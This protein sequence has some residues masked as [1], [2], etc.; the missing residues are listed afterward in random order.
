MRRYRA[1]LNEGSLTNEQIKQL[2]SFKEDEKT[3]L[4]KLQRYY[5]GDNPGIMD[6]VVI[7]GQNQVPVPYG[8]LLVKIV[9]GFMY[10]AGLISYAVAD[11][12]N[13]EDAYF[14]ALE[15]IFQA[16]REAEL[17][18]ELGKDQTVFGEA[19]E[20]HYIDND[21]AVDQFAKVPVTEF[22]PVYN[23]DIKPKLVAGIRYFK[24]AETNIQQ[25]QV[26]VYYAEKIDYF[27]LIGGTLRA[28]ET[29]SHPYGQVPVVIYRNNEDLKGDIEH[30]QK[31]IDAYDVMVSTF[32]DDEEKFAEAILLI[33]GKYLDDET[34][35]KLKKLRVIDNLHEK[36][37]LEY[38]TKDLSTS[39]RKEL[40]DIIRQEIHR[41]SLI[42][43]M[44][45]TSVL[46][47][48]SGEAFIYLFAL[49][50]LLAGE[51]QSYFAQGL[52]KR[53]ELATAVMSYPKGTAAGNPNDIRITFT[54]NL[55]KNLVMYAD[56]VS[57][58]WGM[59]S[60]K[61]LL[62]QLPFIDNAGTELDQINDEEESDPGRQLSAEEVLKLYNAKEQ[63]A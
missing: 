32:L 52:K 5:L 28:D 13:N 62:S 36:D 59:V 41:Q 14:E 12:A 55:P 6:K 40:L 21:E 9:V 60:K 47:Q 33:Y 57:K 45:D 58:L 38:L 61:T 29:K 35:E 44:V 19:Y 17:N 34:V 7:S 15:D 3:D 1:Q 50:E 23:Y 49:F 2:I 31:L 8:R 27:T 51:K 11:E 48:K 43:D 56:M 22:I 26:E 18:T 37:R 54:R 24:T 53:I 63:T 4:L 20:L 39:G 25:Y 46:G 42:P 10:K 30:I 16:N